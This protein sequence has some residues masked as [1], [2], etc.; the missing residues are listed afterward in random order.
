M[1]KAA[2]IIGII[3]GVIIVIVIIAALADP[4]EPLTTSQKEAVRAYAFEIIDE[5]SELYATFE[6][7]EA[8]AKRISDERQAPY[9]M[10]IGY[11]AE[12]RK[13]VDEIDSIE[14]PTGGQEIRNITIN[15]LRS[16]QSGLNEIAS[17]DETEVSLSDPYTFYS[18]YLD[19]LIEIPEL[20]EDI[21]EL[22]AK[23]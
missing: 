6:K 22:L 16:W 4:S 19:V 8:Q 17:K 1:K 10:A 2:R 5:L 20:K 14:C 7:G 21:Q 12:V 9:H 15:E 18:A 23:L 13:T 11:M 3:A